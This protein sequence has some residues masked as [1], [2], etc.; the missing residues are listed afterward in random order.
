MPSIGIAIDSYHC[1]MGVDLVQFDHW[2]N[3]GGGEAWMD[4][5]HAN[6]DGQ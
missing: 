5:Q 6:S 4:T 1:S 3:T 2:P